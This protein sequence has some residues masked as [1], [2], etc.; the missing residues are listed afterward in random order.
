MAGKK[1]RFAGIGC[2]GQGLADISR[3]TT[4]PA[5][6][7]VAFCDIDRRHFAD[8][9]KKW[10]DLPKYS[11]FREMFAEMGDQIDAV[12]VGVPDHQ[13]ALITQAALDAG[14]HVYCEK[15][16]TR[17]VW[18]ARQIANTAAAAGK[19]TR[20]GIQIHSYN[21]YRVIKPV[22]QDLKAI[23]KVKE[24]F[25][26]IDKP[27]HG[28]AGTLAPPANPEKAP[29]EVDWE[30]W[31]GPAPWREYG[32]DGIYHPDSWRDWQDFGGGSI[33]DNGC[34]LLDP[35]FTAL[36]LTAPLSV[37]NEH[38]GMNDEVWPSQ[39][40]ITYTF[41]GNE[42]TAGDTLTVTWHDGY[43]RPSWDIPGVPPCEN[44]DRPASLMVGEK[45]CLLVN[46]FSDPRLFPEKDF[47]DFEWPELEEA[48]HYHG[49]VDACLE[50][51]TELSANFAYAG[52]LTETVQ[53]GNVAAHFPG[54]TLEWDAENFRIT[55]L[56]EANAHLTCDYREGWAVEARG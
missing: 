6:E 50:G 49:W 34:H 2:K 20:M 52:P 42:H 9:D 55:N 33:G 21:R 47:A 17:T 51:N 35:I 18:E 43:L 53:L 45:G 10:P 29:P 30:Q 39:E 8:V 22:V 31:I 41:P 26:W 38:S 24:V 23:G 44:F 4:H 25:S 37:K 32:G 5:V 46:H 3:I 40:K 15:P 19:V 11:D 56:K 13:H 12:S 7:P 54:E 16:L 36:D 48:N 14:F 28:R 27:G 1:L